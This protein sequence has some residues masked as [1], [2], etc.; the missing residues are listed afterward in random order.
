MKKQCFSLW[1]K[2]HTLMCVLGL[3]ASLVLPSGL[4]KAV[5]TGGYPYASFNGPG[6][7]GATS[8]W[9]D[10]QGGTQS[11]YG[12]SYRNCTDYVAWKLR[13][14]GVPDSRTRGL[15]NA[16]T[17][18]ANATAR[19]LEVS[20]RPSVGTVAVSTNHVAYVEA[21]DG[22][23]IT[24]SEYNYATKGSFSKRTG[25][26]RFKGYIN[27]GA[28]GSSAVFGE[29]G[30]RGD[31]LGTNQT[32]HAGQYLLSPDVRFMLV[33]Q[34]D[35]NLVLYGPGRRAL[36]A[37]NTTGSGAQ[38]LIPQ[39]DGNL[40]L[41]TAQWKPVWASWTVGHTNVSLHMQ[42]DGHLVLY[43]PDRAVWWSST[44]Q[45]GGMAYLGTDRLGP[46]NVLQRNQ[47]IRSSDRRRILVL[48]PDGNLVLYG[49][50]QN[51]I[52]HTSTHGKGGA[53][54]VVQG[55][56][57]LVLY[58]AQWRPLWWTGVTHNPASTLVLQEDGN[59]VLY[60][61]GRAVWASWT[62]GRF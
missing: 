55:D 43:R 51:P 35:G 10:A 45:G 19:G 24:V 1:G 7:N 27:F 8:T 46:G 52:W 16:D 60:V 56:G 22:N 11:L 37:T 20:E 40:V 62:V 61:P 36:W 2:F 57:N 23:Q 38:Y 18:L 6:T 32:L 30:Y 44:V 28:S 47:Y 48:Q 41:Y 15:G 50:G 34:T 29:T 17:W 58:D 59:L 14:L 42:A 54:L 3:L 31:Q 26:L 5:E 49:P 12:Y 53:Y 33:L 4:A 9:T 13:S 39:G 21:V 25:A